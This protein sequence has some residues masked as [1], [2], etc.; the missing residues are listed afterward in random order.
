MGKAWAMPFTAAAML[1]KAPAVFPSWT[2]RAVA[3]RR[4][5]ALAGPCPLARPPAVE[6]TG[7][8]IVDLRKEPSRDEEPR[9]RPEDR[10]ARHHGTLLPGRRLS[11][12]P[13]P[14]FPGHR[15]N[16]AVASRPCPDVRQ[17]GA[18]RPAS[19][20]A[21]RRTASKPRL[22]RHLYPFQAVSNG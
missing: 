6:G 13:Q 2:A 18:S 14:A 3:G 1:G 9:S 11:G 17:P 22:R 12:A 19:E 5:G 15:I 16:R 7:E 21:R 8:V 20:A 4:N 10:A